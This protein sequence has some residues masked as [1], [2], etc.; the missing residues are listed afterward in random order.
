MISAMLEDFRR[1]RNHRRS[2][3]DLSYSFSQISRRMTLF[4]RNGLKDGSRIAARSPAQ[5]QE[6]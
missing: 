1:G 5:K 3:L 4:A 6:N 2:R